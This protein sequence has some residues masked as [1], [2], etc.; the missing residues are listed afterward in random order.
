ME[1]L[2][3]HA[4]SKDFPKLSAI[5]RSI[6][7]QLS[8]ESGKFI[9]SQV[10]KG[11]RGKDLEDALEWLISAGL[12]HKVAKIEK[13]FVPLLRMRIRLSSSCICQT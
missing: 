3:M 6:P 12:V 13:P 9:F 2:T 10:R 7:Q 4:P 8:K 11:W 5:W 1:T